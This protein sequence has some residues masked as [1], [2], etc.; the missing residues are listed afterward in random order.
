MKAELAE[1]LVAY[2]VQDL[3]G[4]WRWRVYRGGGQMIRQGVEPTEDGAARAAV[5]LFSRVAP[6]GTPAARQEGVEI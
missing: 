4:H 2:S 6:G 1:E 3:G 5:G